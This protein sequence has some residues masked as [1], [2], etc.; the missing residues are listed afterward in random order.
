MK[1]RKRHTAHSNNRQPLLQKLNNNVL[2]S[3]HHTG[4][5]VGQFQYCILLYVVL[6][7][8]EDQSQWGRVATGSDCSGEQ[9]S[10][11]FGSLA[12]N[13]FQSGDFANLQ[14]E[15]ESALNFQSS[16]Y[17][18]CPFS[19]LNQ[20]LR[21]PTVY[22][23][24]CV[25]YRISYFSYYFIAFFGPK[26]SNYLITMTSQWQ[27]RTLKSVL[28]LVRG[29]G[30]EM[31]RLD[32][33]IF[34][35]HKLHIYLIDRACFPTF[36]R[37]PQMV[38]VGFAEGVTDST[39]FEN[40]FDNCLNSR[41]LFGFNCSSGMYFFEPNFLFFASFE[42]LASLLDSFNFNLHTLICTDIMAIKTENLV[43]AE[44]TQTEWSKCE[45]GIQHR[46]RDCREKK[47]CGLESRACSQS[48]KAGGT[49]VVKLVFI[50][51]N[52]PTEEDVAKLRVEIQNKG[53]NCPK[54]DCCP[55]FG[56]AVGLR[57]SS[58]TRQL[59]WCKRQCEEKGRRLV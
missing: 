26:V 17:H 3:N 12:H 52:Y 58:H 44:E 4:P 29:I 7:Y 46:R 53:F 5:N 36:N 13:F 20:S 2:M 33:E 39:T 16:T 6:V 8:E 24:F 43:I 37:F 15:R 59:E 51:D 25:T 56:C 54:D 40:C 57:F 38:L 10:D 21:D 22:A 14:K 19:N 49:M 28:Q 1:K 18:S 47:N 32:N 30:N 23:M 35:K 48:V 31:K 11:I 42:N 41:E 45:D 50:T 55:V 34:K 27:L 9:S